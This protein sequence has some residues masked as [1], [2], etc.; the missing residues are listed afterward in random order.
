MNRQRG[1]SMLELVLVVILVVT[2][3]MVAIDRLLPLRGD[4]EAAHA[5][6]I[7]GTLRSALGMEV[8][9]RLMRGEM[10]GITALEGANPMGFLA[11]VPDNYLGEIDRMR[12]EQ[13]PRGHWY[14]DS[15]TGELVYLVRYDQYFRTDLAGVPRLVF[16]VELVHNERGDLAGVRLARK[17]AFVWVQSAATAELL[18]RH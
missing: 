14:F 12:P 16:R 18:G 2:L 13:L 9:A 10:D 6:T 1:F 11:E 7:A 15:N 8:A 3:Y 4:A 5:A 17:N